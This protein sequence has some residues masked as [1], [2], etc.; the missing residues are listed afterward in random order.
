M[1]TAIPDAIV[2]DYQHLIP[3]L[4]LP[5][6]DDRHVLAAAIVAPVDMIV[7][8][9]LKDF[10]AEIIERYELE[11]ITPDEL[12]CRLLARDVQAIQRVLEEVRLTLRHPPY[13]YEQLIN[14]LKAVGL[15][16]TAKLLLN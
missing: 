2:F 14:R 12:L 4:N 9:N 1:E 15:I 16:K 8:W 7:T 13:T 10:P 5:D 6:R 3:T 11:V